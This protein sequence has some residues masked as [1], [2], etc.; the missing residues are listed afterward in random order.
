MLAGN[1]RQYVG[2]RQKQEYYMIKSLAAKK[3]SVVLVQRSTTCQPHWLQISRGRR[4][5]GV[6]WKRLS[7]PKPL[8]R[9]WQQKVSSSSESASHVIPLS[10][11]LNAFS[12]E[13]RRLV[14]ELRPWEASSLMLWTDISELWSLSQ[15]AQHHWMQDVT[16]ARVSGREKNAYTN[17]TRRCV[18]GVTF[19][20]LMMFHIKHRPSQWDSSLDVKGWANFKCFIGVFLSL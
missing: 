7:G 13:K 1:L 8:L 14:R 17:Y 2:T 3:R 9:S 5:G 11:S 16:R 6:Y 20:H 10:M 12:L 4:G 18:R 15:C 19:A